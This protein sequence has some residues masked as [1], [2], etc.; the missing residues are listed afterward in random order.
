MVEI[1]RG[2]TRDAEQVIELWD[3]FG[4]PTRHPGRYEEL[5]RL[6]DRDPESLLIAEVNGAVVGTLIVGWDGWRCHLYRLVVESQFR[7]VGAA[8]QLAAAAL[9][10]ARA[11]GAVRL[12]AS[13]DPD[14]EPAVRFWESIGYAM[15]HDRRWSLA[16]DS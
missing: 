4:G 11:L 2:D 13:V 12:D 7:R 5:A 8:R 10:R 6:L 1:R 15:D 16:V 9:Q 14:N 3:R